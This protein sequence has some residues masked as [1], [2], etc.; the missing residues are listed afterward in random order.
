MQI[1][2]KTRFQFPHCVMRYNIQTYLPFLVKKW[3]KRL[4][5]LALLASSW[6]P[7]RHVFLALFAG[8]VLLR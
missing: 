4:L 2:L 6:L 1:I 5:V 7:F 8:V 3:N